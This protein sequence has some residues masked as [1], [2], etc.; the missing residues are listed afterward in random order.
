MTRGPFHKIFSLK[1]YILIKSKDIFFEYQTFSSFEING[2]EFLL[3]NLTS[4]GER[5]LTNDLKVSYSE[6]K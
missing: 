4:L 6:V 2:W 3:I 1:K 5:L